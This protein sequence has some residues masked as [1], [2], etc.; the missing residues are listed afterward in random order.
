M[1]PCLREENIRISNGLCERC[2]KVQREKKGGKKANDVELGREGTSD[3]ST[4]GKHFSYKTDSE[5]G[6]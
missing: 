4:Q 1:I 5:I 6:I 2:L 3:F